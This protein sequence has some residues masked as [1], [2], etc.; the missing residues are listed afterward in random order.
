MSAIESMSGSCT[1]L[2]VTKNVVNPNTSGAGLV[3]AH[4]NIRAIS[5]V[6]VAVGVTANTKVWTCDGAISAGVLG[7]PTGTFWLFVV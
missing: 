7:E 5:S 2:A 6:N 1:V 3:F 4:L